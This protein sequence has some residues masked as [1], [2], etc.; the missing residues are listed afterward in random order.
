M[1]D[2][3]ATMIVLGLLAAGASWITPDS[4]QLGRWSMALLMLGAPAYLLHAWIERR[5]ERM[6]GQPPEPPE[7]SPPV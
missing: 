6:V 7:G 4:W 5:R 1:R 3:G 2:L